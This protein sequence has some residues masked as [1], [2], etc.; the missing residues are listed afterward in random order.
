MLVLGADIGG[1]NARFA[2]FD[3]TQDVRRPVFQ[4]V[5]PSASAE[6]FSQ[7]LSQFLVECPAPV[8]AGCLGVAGPVRGGRCDVTNLPWVL[9]EADLSR[10]FSFRHLRLI[11]DLEASAWG[12]EFLTADDLLTVLPG[13]PAAQANRAVIAAGTGLGEAGIVWHGT[14]YLPFATEGGHCD[15][16]PRGELQQALLVY[17]QGLVQHVSYEEIL[18]GRGI[19][20]LFDFFVDRLEIALSEEFYAAVAAAGKAATVSAWA[21][22]EKCPACKYALEL[23]LAILGQEASNLALKTMATGGV[24]LG[25]GIAAKLG[26]AIQRSQAFVD[27]FQNKGKMSGVLQQVPVNVILNPDTALLGAGAVARR[28]LTE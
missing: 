24:Y 19:E 13:R 18:C 11:N 10:R 16:G 8:D 2:V 3:P 1:T 22:Q 5:Y 23:Y 28:L 7:L 4:K 15:F 27:G 25:G 21:M 20:R 9:E 14:G 12:I 26:S 17:L 6:D